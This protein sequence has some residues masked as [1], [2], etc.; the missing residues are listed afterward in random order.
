MILAIAAAV[1]L[2]GLLVGALER[3]SGRGTELAFRRHLVAELE[4]ARFRAAQVEIML[5]EVRTGALEL[6]PPAVRDHMVISAPSMRPTP[7]GA[8]SSSPLDLELSI[9]ALPE[10]LKTELRA[11]EGDDVQRE[12]L[13]TIVRELAAG[14]DPQQL[15]A[16]LFDPEG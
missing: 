13:E 6:S 9:D 7:A 8:S 15:A 5:D 2:L 1:A 3:R 12:Y 4:L 14:A 11:I 10:V 16:R